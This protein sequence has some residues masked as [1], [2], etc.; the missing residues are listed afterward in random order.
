MLSKRLLH[1]R[2]NNLFWGETPVALE[3]GWEKFD[4]LNGHFGKINLQ[5]LSWYKNICQY[6]SK[7][8]WLIFQKIYWHCHNWT[9]T[10]EWNF[11]KKIVN[12]LLLQLSPPMCLL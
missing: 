1:E 11:F 3:T 8:L 12:K 9:G 2:K 6:I 7:Q 5:K 10:S 4:V